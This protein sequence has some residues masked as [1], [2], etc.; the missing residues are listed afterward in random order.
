MVNGGNMEELIKKIA[1]KNSMYLYDP[2]FLIIIKSVVKSQILSVLI[3]VNLI[4]LSILEKMC[5]NTFLLVFFEEL[6]NFGSNR[7]IRY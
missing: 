7:L 2:N 6:K 1:T 5:F 3:I 4:Q